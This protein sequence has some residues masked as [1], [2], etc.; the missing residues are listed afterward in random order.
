MADHVPSQAK[1]VGWLALVLMG[2]A[3]L[4]ALLVA[5]AAMNAG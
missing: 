3:I 2:L 5:I 1:F 4:A